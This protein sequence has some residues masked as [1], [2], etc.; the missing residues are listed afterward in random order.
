MT[1]VGTSVR[2]WTAGALAMLALACGGETRETKPELRP[3]RT[4]LVAVGAGDTTRTLAGVARAGVESRL[5]FRVPGTVRTVEVA[6]GDRVGRGQVLARLDP[7]DYEL[8]VEEAQ[9]ALAQGEAALRRA[10][11]DYDR[12]RALYENNNASKSELDAARAG[13]ES[14]MAQVDAADKRLE[15]ARQQVGYTVLR[16]P[17]DGAIASVNVEVNENVDSGQEVFLLNSGTEPEIEIAVPEVLIARVEVGQPV[18]VR[19]D[20]LPGRTLRA[21]V[22]EVGVAVTGTASTF[23]VKARL[24]EPAPEIRSGMAAEASFVFAGGGGSDRIV[25]PVVAVGEDLEGRYVFVLERTGGGEG[26]VRRRSVVVDERSARLGGIEVL[27]GLA[28]GEE[29]VT[30]GVRVLTDGMR[31]RVMEYEGGRA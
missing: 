12:V 23:Q 30:A 15:Q 28:P 3:V 26:T 8:R 10:E 2:I 24:T 29:V 25:V 4:H 22:A 27:E 21:E 20:A 11:A 16:A 31:V 1:R 14:A 5:S 18:T 6:L 19:L 13:A 7:T 17:A 9:A